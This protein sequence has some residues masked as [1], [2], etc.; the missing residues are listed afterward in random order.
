LIKITSK[1]QFQDVYKRLFTTRH[2]MFNEDDSANLLGRHS[3]TDL[4][5]TSKFQFQNVYGR[6]FVTR[7]VIFNEDSANLFERHSMT[8]LK[9]S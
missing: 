9:L 3:I 4:K 5:T 8:D 7:H 6:L 2:V 1:V